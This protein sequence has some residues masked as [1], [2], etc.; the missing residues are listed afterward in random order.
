MQNIREINQIFSLSLVNIL[1]PL[2]ILHPAHLVLE[3][4]CLLPLLDRAAAEE[5]AQRVE[6][7]AAA[8]QQLTLDFKDD[9]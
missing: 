7:R 9:F 8:E 4:D 1:L 3:V 6:E 2:L 5:A